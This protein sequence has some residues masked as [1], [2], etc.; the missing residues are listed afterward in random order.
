MV[1]S[2]RKPALTARHTNQRK[3]KNH[4]VPLGLSAGAVG[5]SS[6]AQ[7][8]MGDT[9]ALELPRPGPLDLNG[10]EQ[11]LLA[12]TN[13]GS[14]S[15]AAPVS[16][17]AESVL[18]SGQALEAGAVRTE[19]GE[20]VRISSNSPLWSALTSTPIAVEDLGIERYHLAQNTDQPE[21][22]PAPS[23]EI[24]LDLLANSALAG[25]FLVLLALLT[26]PTEE[27]DVDEVPA[28]VPLG[29]G[30]LFPAHESTVVSQRGRV[31][32][33]DDLTEL[34]G[35]LYFNAVDGLD[36]DSDTQSDENLYAY[37]PVSQTTEEISAV[38]ALGGTYDVRPEYFETF[39]GK[40]YF[41]GHNSSDEEVLMV[42]DP[43]ANTAE[44]VSS[45]AAVNPTGEESPSYMASRGSKLYFS[46]DNGTH[47]EL[48]VYDIDTDT[49]TLVGEGTDVSTNAEETA[50][51]YL[52]WLRG[53]LYFSGHDVD[54]KEELY[55]YD[56]EEG[57]TTLVETLHPG[58]RTGDN[59][60]ESNPGHLFAYGGKLY[61]N[62]EEL[63]GEENFFV[64]DPDSGQTE[65]IMSV[66]NLVEGKEVDPN[67]IASMDGV[68]YF[69]GEKSSGYDTLMAYRPSTGEA[70]LVDSVMALDTV[71]IETIASFDG[72]LYLG[73]EIRDDS[74]ELFYYDPDILFA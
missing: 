57:S 73:I 30:T 50:P 23:D 62:S 6:L 31:S 38:T 8:E 48:Y 1:N 16:A 12:Q 42:Y 17:V 68:L 37:D 43:E 9:M 18:I 74:D 66:Y 72:V 45:V 25:S 4:L 5:W 29:R 39:R 13:G 53:K 46:A 65:K 35:L 56:P 52:A 15:F 63:N 3:R 51:D 32:D 54:G 21:P 64:Y 10:L 28:S 24:G 11:P 19:A 61:F 71:E 7:A 33:H 58:V 67:Y 40:L 59:D 69:A 27:P 14:N 55:V 34:G 26:R 70:A 2:L 22:E 41:R 36:K 20:V 49:T 60:N 44:V 47:E